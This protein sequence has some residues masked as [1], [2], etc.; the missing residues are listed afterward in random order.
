M[1]HSIDKGEDVWKKTT[2]LG[3]AQDSVGYV[4]NE[5]FKANVPADVQ[6]AMAKAAEDVKSG[7]KKIKSYFDFANENEFNDYIATAQ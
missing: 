6:D 7:A 2:T 3:L 4:N 1:V 5:F